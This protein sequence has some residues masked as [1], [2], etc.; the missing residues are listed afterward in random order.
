M[1]HS[2]SIAHRRRRE[3]RCPYCAAI[4]REHIDGH[5]V[6]RLMSPPPPP[7]MPISRRAA[8]RVS[9]AAARPSCRRTR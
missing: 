5:S 8:Y 6:L 3:G 9:Q 7:P 2:A 1:T 4:I